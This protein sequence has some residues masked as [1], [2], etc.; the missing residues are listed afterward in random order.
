[1]AWRRACGEDGGAG[2]GGLGRTVVATRRPREWVLPWLVCGVPIFLLIAVAVGLHV[3]WEVTKTTEEE[4][5]QLIDR[6]LSEGASTAEILSFL[7]AEGIDHGTV[8]T[9]EY[10]SRVL[11]A[12]YPP[13]TRII[14]AI[15]RDTSRSFL[16]TGDIQVF[17]ILDQE[18]RLY[19]YIVDESF[20]S[21]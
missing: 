15:I 21:L 14:V 20:T 3:Y 18:G 7:G 8:H 13:T 17:F 1:M 6:N 11:D 19:D 10:A 5:V 9:A 16:G 2:G 12:G 4:V